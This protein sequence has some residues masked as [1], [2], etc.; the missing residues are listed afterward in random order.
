MLRMLHVN[1]PAFRY[2]VGTPLLVG[3]TCGVAYMF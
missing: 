1:S 2:K 3:L